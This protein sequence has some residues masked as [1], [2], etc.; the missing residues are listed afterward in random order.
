MHVFSENANNTAENVMGKSSDED[1]DSVRL[2]RY[3]CKQKCLSKYYVAVG[4]SHSSRAV[5][6]TLSRSTFSSR[7]LGFFLL[8]PHV[9]T[10]HWQN[11]E[12]VSL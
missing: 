8:Y 1:K 7:Y 11:T 9:F 2:I 12:I 5:L 3:D 4:S 6:A 10:C